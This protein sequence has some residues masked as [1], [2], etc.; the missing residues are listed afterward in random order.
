MRLSGKA[1]EIS[2]FLD[3][4]TIKAN[5]MS[6]AVNVFAHCHRFYTGRRG[7]FHQISKL[8]IMPD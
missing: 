4:L 7:K 5:E 6:G 8:S 1:L 3:A 2:D